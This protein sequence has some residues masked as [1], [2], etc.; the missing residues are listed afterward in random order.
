MKSF[1]L[2]ALTCLALGLTAFAPAQTPPD[3]ATTASSTPGAAPEQRRIYLANDDHTDYMWTADADTSNQVFIDLIDFHLKLADETATNPSPYRARFNAD[4]SHWL[5]NYERKKSPAEFERVIAR[6]K[7]GTLSAPLNTLVSCYGG[8]PAEAVLRGLYYAGRLERR[9]DLRF[10]MA[11]ATENQVLPLGLTSLFAGSGAKYTWR[12]VCGCASKLPFKGVLNQRPREIYWAAGH[13]GQRLLMKWYSLGPNGIGGYWEAGSPEKVIDYVSTNEG[14]KSRYI[15]PV[16]KKPYNIIGLFGYGGDDLAR[17]TG[18]T[19]PPPIPAV[20]GLPEV[21]SSPYCDHFHII[22]QKLS[23]DQSQIIVSNEL[24]FFTDFESHY[25]ATLDTLAVTYGNEWDLYSAS[26]AETSARVKR[27]VEK[28]RAAELLATLVSLKYPA[29]MGN[30]LGARDRAFQD[31]GLYWEHDWTADGPVTRGQRA[32]WQ[33]LLATEIEYYVDSIHSEALLRLGGMIPRPE[34]ANRF[35]VLNPLGWPRTDYA[36]HAHPGSKDIHVHD[37]T[38]GQDVPHQIVTLNHVQY[39]RILAAD[40]PSAGY[41]VYE[42]RPGPGAAKTDPSA[43]ANISADGDATFE[44]AAVKL[45]VARDGAIRSL[46]DKRRGGTEL[47]ATLDGLALNDFAA[48]SNE[49][50]P[51]RVENVGPVSVTLRA[52]SDAGLPHT[53]AITLYRDSDRIDIRNEITT[54][55]ADTR[56]WSFGF[57]LKDPS[58]RTEEVGTINLNKLRSQGGDYADTH[59]RYDHITLNHFADLTAGDGTRGITLSNPDLAFAKLGHSTLTS[60]DT[61]TPQINVLAGG[62]IDGPSLG[63]RGQNDE[64]HFLQRFALRAHADYDQVA[65]MKFALEHQNP[66]VAAPILS[67]KNTCPYDEKSYSLLTISDPNVLLWSVKVAEE[68]I[69]HGVIARLWNL[70][71]KPATAQLAFTPGVA[72]ARRTTHIETDLEPVAIANDGTVP[73]SYARQQLQTYRLQQK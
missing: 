13:D 16:S 44:N 29:F 9:Y 43:T 28:L 38:A 17:K 22:A 48:N 46:I 6:L 53:T 3:T 63:I 25:G 35:F 52:R 70:A 73:T 58:I 55:F 36:D 64:T 56:Y 12:G 59:A 14:F 66:L 31:L 8:Q 37:L 32:A 65:A 54:N 23:N 51:L 61:T 50:E 10:T 42:I 62:Q 5:W 15:D 68:G 49:G 11:N 18:V 20:P 4:G 27:S 21:P 67:K 60:L 69:D 33:N 71:D 1:R 40:V 34:K 30:H 24:D 26:L 57:N 7:D 72:T 19:P 39:I 47:A 41:K 2:S 45:V